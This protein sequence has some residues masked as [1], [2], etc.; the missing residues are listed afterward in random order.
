MISRKYTKRVEIWQ[1]V[2]VPDGYGGNTVTEELISKS[3]ANIKSGSTSFSRSQVLANLGIVDQALS[4]MVTLRK[5]K[6]LPYNNV[7]QFIMYEGLKYIIQ[8]VTEK[9]FENVEVEII[10]TRE[11]MNNVPVITT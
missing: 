10:A 1:T 2:N 5:R 11:V 3:W 8:T 4:I 9:D 7:N 6:D